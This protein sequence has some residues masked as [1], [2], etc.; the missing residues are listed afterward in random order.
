MGSGIIKQASQNCIALQI[1]TGQ[2]VATIRKSLKDVV[3][4]LKQ[5]RHLVSPKARVFDFVNF[6]AEYIA[7]A[8]VAN[9]AKWTWK[10]ATELYVLLIKPIPS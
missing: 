10:A 8:T 3:L 2:E 7:S 6:E 9:Q 1:A 4:P 5:P